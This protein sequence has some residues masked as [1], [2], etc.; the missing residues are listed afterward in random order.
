[1]ATPKQFAAIIK[2]I[3]TFK[4]YDAIA[5]R[6]NKFHENIRVQIS[7]LNNWFLPNRAKYSKM[8]QVKFVEDSL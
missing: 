7:L 5:I 6:E 3:V 8:D 4:R 2:D 1:M